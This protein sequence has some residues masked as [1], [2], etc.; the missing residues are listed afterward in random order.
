M[1]MQRQIINTLAALAMLAGAA[2]AT[3][4]L[5]ANTAAFDRTGTI[6]W[7]DTKQS[8][9]NIVIGDR[10]YTIGSTVRVHT[11]QGTTGMSALR[12]GVRVGYRSINGMLSDLWVLPAE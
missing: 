1:I 2:L 5:A 9:N 10:S 8:T 7:V 6:D 12:P 4:A 11:P 3:P